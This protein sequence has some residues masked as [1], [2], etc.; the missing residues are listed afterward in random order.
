MQD[1]NKR[2]TKVSARDTAIVLLEAIAC[3]TMDPHIMKRSF[4]TVMRR[5]Q[6]RK[7][8][9]TKSKIRIRSRI[10][11]T[12]TSRWKPERETR[13]ELSLKAHHCNVDG[14]SSSSVTDTIIE[15]ERKGTCLSVLELRSNGR[16]KVGANSEIRPRLRRRS[17][18]PV[19]ET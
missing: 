8:P 4:R 19:C 1:I 14:H 12:S 11:W 13:D 18:R 5:K 9:K 17:G 3:G 2:A 10:I 7:F 15:P 6:R 16:C